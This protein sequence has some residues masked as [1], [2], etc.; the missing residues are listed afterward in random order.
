MVL[1]SQ[2]SF[3]PSKRVVKLTRLVTV[4]D[5]DAMRMILPGIPNLS[6][7]RPAACAVNNA[8][9]VFTSST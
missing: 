2:V 7:C 8:P 9:L 6:I 1:G 4:P 5:I 3:L